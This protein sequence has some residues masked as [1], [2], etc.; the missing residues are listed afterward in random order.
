MMV[1]FASSAQK[2]DDYTLNTAELGVTPSTIK[3]IEKAAKKGDLAAQRQLGRYYL[4]LGETDPINFKTSYKW[5]I[6]AIIEHND[7]IAY[8][9]LA[10][11]HEK[12]VS[13]AFIWDVAKWAKKDRSLYDR[14]DFG[15]EGSKLFYK[16]NT[17]IAK[18]FLR[19]VEK[20]EN[21][22]ALVLLGK[23]VQSYFPSDAIEYYKKAADK[24]YAEA[25]FELG[26]CYFDLYAR[27][28]K[29][30]NLELCKKWLGKAAEQNLEKASTM[31]SKI[32]QAEKD[33]KI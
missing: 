13:D 30:W 4:N 1:S 10:T 7:P 23:K 14:Y 20:S 9:Y 28:K 3:D 29:K 24:G 22:E 26:S 2:V 15:H 18:D 12:G 19:V 27:D 11:M 8:F 6:T 5:F 25:Q 17:E 21:A 33:G 16:R 32:Q 31:L